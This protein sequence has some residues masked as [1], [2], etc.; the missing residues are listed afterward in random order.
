MNEKD[1]F[2][3]DIE[4]VVQEGFELGLSPTEI[5]KMVQEVIA[6]ATIQFTK[7]DSFE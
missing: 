7:E 4:V 2:K 5:D 1:S 3:Q 6:W